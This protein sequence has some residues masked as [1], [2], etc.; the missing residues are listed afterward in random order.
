EAGSVLINKQPTFR[1][2]N[3][4]FGGF[5]L[6]GIGKEGVKYAVE[7]MTRCKLVVIG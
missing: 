4:P 7:D 2:D 6:S 5:K 1:T 3:M